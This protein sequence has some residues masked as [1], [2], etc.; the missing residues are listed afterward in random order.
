MG[1][2][3]TR[4]AV[5][6]LF[7]GMTPAFAADAPIDGAPPVPQVEV[8]DAYEPSALT[9]SQAS[10]EREPAAARDKDDDDTYDFSWLDPDKRI[11][12]LQNRKFRKAN[13][14][15]FTLMTGIGTSN[16]Y[17]NT[18][19][20]EPRVAYYLSESLG[21]EVF[22]TFTSN[23]Q[24]NTYN[25]L[26][27]NTSTTSALPVIRE[28]RSQYGL[29]AHWSPWY[30]KINVFN[31]VLYFDWYFSAGLGSLNSYLDTNTLVG[32]PSNFIQQSLFA[33]MVGTG[34]QYHLNQKWIVRLDFMGALY[35]APLFG[36]A[37]NSSLFSNYNFNFGIGVKL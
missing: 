34:H 33:F 27:R 28:I 13:H 3:R 4:I 6:C 22:G 7:A 26:S 1:R 23:V 37:G 11:Y 29:L 2:F 31:T 25:A 8:Y 12:V 24:N 32:A 17:R 35:T 9:T 15:L 21:I 30:A 5:V 20:L 36:N 10:S 16:P 14:A 19:N 18:Y